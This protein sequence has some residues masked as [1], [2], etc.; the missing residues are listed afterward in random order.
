MCILTHT[1]PLPPLTH[2]PT[3][4][5]PHPLPHSPTAPP[6]APPTHCPTHCPTHSPTHPLTHCPHSPTAPLTAPPTHPLTH[7]PTAPTHPPTHPLPH[8]P[9]HPLGGEGSSAA[10]RT[11]TAKDQRC[12]VRGLPSFRERRGRGRPPQSPVRHRLLSHS[13]QRCVCLFAFINGCVSV[14]T[15]RDVFITVCG[16]QNHR[17]RNIQ[18]Q[19]N[20]SM[21]K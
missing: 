6:T 8:C 21:A 12:C 9:T 19:V 13:T 16:L 11:G 4:P 15:Y 3:H 14:Y 5:L 18:L 10:E 7:S 2:S 17:L 20:R 1:L